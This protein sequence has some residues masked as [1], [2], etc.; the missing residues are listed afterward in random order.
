VTRILVRHCRTA[1][2]GQRFCGWND[3]PLSEDG[4]RDAIALAGRFSAADGPIIASPLERA[5]ATAREIAR[6][7]GA[8]ITP[9]AR[10]REVDCGAAD[11]LTF[12]EISAAF[13]ALAAA[14]LSSQPLVD[15][16][17]GERYAD[18]AARIDAFWRD[19]PER[20]IVVTHGGVLGHLLRSIPDASGTLPPRPSPGTLLRVAGPPWRVVAHWSPL[21]EIRP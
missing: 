13:P 2:S 14:L 12:D 15:W 16:P 20:A 9:D 1:W 5:A 10:L 18:L 3:P 17:G 4:R 21:A 19:C 11:G 6:Y 7:T 8:R